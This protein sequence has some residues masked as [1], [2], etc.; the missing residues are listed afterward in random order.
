MEQENIPLVLVTLDFEKAFDRVERESL[1]ETLRFF[2]FGE[3]LIAWSRVLYNNFQLCTINAGEISEWFYPIRGLQQG[4]PISSI[5]FILVVEIL[6]QN[7]RQNEETEGIKIGGQE[8]KSAQFA[9]DTNLF[10][11][12]KESVFAHTIQTVSEFEKKKTPG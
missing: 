7:I 9:D 6:S 12:F 1:Y 3:E 10:L 5:Y 11:K 8:F 2:N 4:N